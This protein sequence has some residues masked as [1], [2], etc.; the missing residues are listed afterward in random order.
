MNCARSCENLLNVVKVIPKALL[1]PFYPDTVILAILA[2]F[3]YIV[4]IILCVQ[5]FD[6]V[7]WAAGRASGL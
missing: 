5:C 2:E 3:S 4:V 1:V 7:G 6:A